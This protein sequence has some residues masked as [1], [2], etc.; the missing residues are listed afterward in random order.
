MNL[1][2]WRSNSGGISYQDIKKSAG[3]Y[4]VVSYFQNDE[5]LKLAFKY[6]GASRIQISEN[7]RTL[8]KQSNEFKWKSGLENWKFQSL[9]EELSYLFEALDE[10]YISSMKD[11][12]EQPASRELRTVKKRGNCSGKDTTTFLAYPKKGLKNE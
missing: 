11:R 7:V 2:Y 8:K 3:A 5:A 10:F 4:F 1:F 9:K 6:L 12:L